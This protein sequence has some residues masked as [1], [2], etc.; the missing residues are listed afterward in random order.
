RGPRFTGDAFPI[1]S[2]AS[3]S[4]SRANISA[5][6]SGTIAYATGA[7]GDNQLVW[8]DRTGKRL[9]AVGPPAAYNEL[10]LS[11][12]GRR[13]AYDLTDRPSG[14]VQIWVRDLTRD[15]ASRITFGVGNTIWPVWSPDGRRI[16]YS[17][18]RSGAFSLYVREA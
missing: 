12:D 17:S 13:L 5:S 7:Q 10:A 8:F 4:G 15:V 2:G 11:P 18:D 9:G 1:A 14:A 6:T 3:A 16:G